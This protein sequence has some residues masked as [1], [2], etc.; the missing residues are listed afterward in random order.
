[1]NIAYDQNV[2]DTERHRRQIRNLTSVFTQ[3]TSIAY[4]EEAI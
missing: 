3:N 2:D 1:M 4:N